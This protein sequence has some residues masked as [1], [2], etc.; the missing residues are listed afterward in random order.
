MI[1]LRPE[2]EKAFFFALKCFL[3][4]FKIAYFILALESCCFMKASGVSNLENVSSFCICIYKYVHMY[5]IYT[6][7]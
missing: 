6:P 5:N 2:D 4:H 3:L 7:F 1:Y